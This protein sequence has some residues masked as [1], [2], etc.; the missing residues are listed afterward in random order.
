MSATS[1]LALARYYRRQG[2]A[3]VPVLHR[4]KA[5]GW[6]GRRQPDW[7]A[8]ELSS[9]TEHHFARPSNLG[10][11]VGARSNHLAD[12]DLDCLEAVEL[13]PRFLPL[14]WTFGRA[15]K[16]RSHWLYRAEGAAFEVFR[17]V[18]G[19]VGRAGATLVELRAGHDEA[20]QTVFPPSIHRDSGESVEW[21]DDGDASDGPRVLPAASLRSSVA[22][23]AAAALV[24][25]HAGMSSTL[26][27]VTGGPVPKLSRDVARLVRQ[28]H[29]LSLTSSRTTSSSQPGVPGDRVLRA[30][31]YLSCIPGA[32][33]GQG[34]H[35]A[36]WLAALAMVRG[37]ALPEETALEL[38]LSGF[39]ARCSPPWSERELR[40]KVASA[41]KDANSAIGYLL[42]SSRG[43]A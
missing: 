42:G 40:H 6:N 41:A 4:D 38:L 15:G 24:A 43:V 2:W 35:Q 14:T 7:G 31:R 17:D 1:T 9:E 27:W 8:F 18:R 11:I 19:S 32:V 30:R 33:S 28:W 13:A 16:P 36:T 5:P 37:F 10:V 22:S 26:E 23:L 21:T 20:R 29:G 39:N 25:R 3:V 34:G 12:V